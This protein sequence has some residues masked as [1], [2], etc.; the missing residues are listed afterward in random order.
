MICFTAA[1]TINTPK[2]PITKSATFTKKKANPDLVHI[3]N[4]NIIAS[5][6]MK[7]I[8]RVIPVFLNLDFILYLISSVLSKS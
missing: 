5:K 1:Q 4:T 2:I 8:E 7:A 3:T 6:H